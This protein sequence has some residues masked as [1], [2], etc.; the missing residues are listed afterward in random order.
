MVANNNSFF[1]IKRNHEHEHT[2]QRGGIEEGVKGVMKWLRVY[3]NRG[4]VDTEGS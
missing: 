4:I 2:Q 3:T 1:L